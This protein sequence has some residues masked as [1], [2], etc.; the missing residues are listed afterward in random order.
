MT[1][2]QPPLPA[3]HG[4]MVLHLI[5]HGEVALDG[6]ERV[7]G[8]L[9]MP[10]SERGRQQLEWVGSALSNA[11]LQFVYASDLTRAQIG[12]ESVA[13]HHGLTVVIEPAFREIFRGAWRGLTWAE[14]D[15][16]FPGGAAR[17]VNE[18]ETYRDHGGETLLDVA[19]RV[20]PAFDQLIMNNAGATEGAI[21]SHSWVIRV[22]LARFLRL[23]PAAALSV[24]AD[25]ASISTVR[26]TKETGWRI[27]QMNRS[28]E[29]SGRGNTSKPT[30]NRPTG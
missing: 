20:N 30:A 13:K 8:D 16:Q 27:Q 26:Y 24:H 21:V 12:A 15:R 7:Y 29:K 2:S 23:R 1:R 19:N 5:R 22:L 14:V 25:T 28:V 9:E 3:P 11:S 4:P 18:S 17:F 10:L 6:P